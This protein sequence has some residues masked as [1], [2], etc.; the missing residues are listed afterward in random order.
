MC[1]RWLLMGAGPPDNT[2]EALQQRRIDQGELCWALTELLREWVEDGQDPEAKLAAEHA[3]Y[4]PLH[5]YDD[6]TFDSKD[7]AAIVWAGTA[8]DESEASLDAAGLDLPPEEGSWPSWVRT[9]MMGQGAG[10][11]HGC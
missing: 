10:V 7:P 6:S 9:S 2:P 11:G 4:L 8:P 1:A 3:A 5:Y